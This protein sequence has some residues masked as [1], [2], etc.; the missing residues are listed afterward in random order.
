MKVKNKRIRFICVAVC[1]VLA[2]FFSLVPLEYSKNQRVNTILE[3]ILPLTFAIP[4]VFLVLQTDRKGLIG[5]LVSLFWLL[6]CL[7]VAISSLPWLSLI[8]GEIKFASVGGLEIVLFFI[9][10]LWIATFEECIFRGII[11]P[12]CLE[13]LS[14]TNKGFLGA[15]FLSSI[16]FG[17]AHFINLIYGA[18]FVGTLWQVGY[19]TLIGGLFAFSLIK[20][21]TIFA[22]ILLH[23]VYNFCGL[24]LDNRVGLGCGVVW[25]I[26]SIITTAIIGVLVGVAVLIAVFRCSK[27]ERQSLYAR[28]NISA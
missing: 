21:K 14:K 11:F 24:L 25:N 12:Y 28:M 10:C 27:E 17:F 2:L 6:P 20:M 15:F 13:R 8:K 1:L 22:P 19:T 23:F 26:S 16:I 3:T 7:L 5:R 18:S 9:Y 4:L